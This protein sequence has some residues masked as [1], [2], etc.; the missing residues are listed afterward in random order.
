MRTDRLEQWARL[1]VRYAI[2]VRRGSTV[3]VRGTLE[4]RPLIHAVLAELVRA[5]AHPRVSVTLPEAVHTFCT[6]GTRE[7][8]GHCSPIDL[9]EARRLDG[10]ITIKS[11]ANTREMSGIAPEK[12]VW[13]AKAARRLNEAIARKDNWTLTLYPTAAYAQDA[14]MAVADFEAFVARAMFLDCEDPVRHWQQQGRRQDKLARRLMQ[15][16]MVRITGRD[17]DLTFGIAGRTAVND[18]GRRNLPGGEVFTAPAES[19]AEGHIAYSYPVA[20]YGREITDIRCEFKRGILVKASA[21]KHSE[22]LNR[23]LDMDA[24]ARRLGE[25][26]IGMNNGVTRF[27]R[28]ILFDEKMG[29]TIHLAVG[30]SYPQCGGRNR[31]ALHWDMIKDLRDG[32]ALYF[33]GALVQKDGRFVV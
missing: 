13:M 8:L 6:L 32:G 10:I 3:K 4:A 26:G 28:N 33:D 17:T 2:R 18:D 25:F 15:T 16:R 1:L 12:Q 22:F 11:E 19:S 20:A 30:R 21:G 31:S 9:H 24:G 5:G 14:D 23:M 7:Q 29:G 27:S